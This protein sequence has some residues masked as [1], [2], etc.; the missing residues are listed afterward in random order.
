MGEIN[1]A[2]RG[3]EGDRSSAEGDKLDTRRR[4]ARLQ[5]QTAEAFR[6]GRE[7]AAGDRGPAGVRKA[8]ASK[9]GSIGSYRSRT[10]STFCD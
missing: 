7:L 5:R 9:A 3:V 8:R 1:S 2:D 6:R 10:V 4:S